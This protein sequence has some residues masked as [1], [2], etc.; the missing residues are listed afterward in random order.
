MKSELSKIL[1]YLKEKTFKSKYDFKSNH[2]PI[3]KDT[4]TINKSTYNK[5]YRRQSAFSLI[6]LSIVLIII[7]FIV[8]GVV[9]AQGLIESAKTRAVITELG[10][11][12]REVIVFK[13]RFNA[14]PGD[15]D[16]AS[17]TLSDSEGNTV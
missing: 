15:Y 10:I 9:I 14:F 8:A 4:T 17:T 12:D 6:E 11:Y 2:T 13:D 1:N 3:Y 16:E 7:G 5:L